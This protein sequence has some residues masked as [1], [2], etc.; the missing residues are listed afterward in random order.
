MRYN[1]HIYIYIIRNQSV[2][3]ICQYWSKSYFIYFILLT[4]WILSAYLVLFDTHTVS[5]Q[6]QIILLQSKQVYQHILSCFTH[7][8]RKSV[9][10][11]KYYYNTLNNFISLSCPVLHTHIHTVRIQTKILLLQPKQFYQHILSC[12]TH[13]YTQSVLKHKLYY[14]NLNKFISI[15]CS[16][17]HTI[18][19]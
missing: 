13:T 3:L 14:Y 16:V 12:L 8:Y 2:N 15:T 17:W 6:T 1:L 19:Q 4:R 7:T 5:T 18:C 10:K 11:H 9:F